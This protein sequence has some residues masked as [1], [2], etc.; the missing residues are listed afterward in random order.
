MND[1]LMDLWIVPSEALAERR[2]RQLAQ[3][4]PNKILLGE[5]VQSLPHFLRQITQPTQPVLQRAIQFQWIRSL[6]K[7]SE[8]RYFNTVKRHPFLAHLFAD[9]LTRLKKQGITP[10]PLEEMLSTTGSLKEYDLLKVFHA[11]EKEKARK[12]WLD[13]EDLYT[14]PI[15][16]NALQ[17]ITTLHFE[18]FWEIPPPLEKIIGE[19]KKLF[20]V[21]IHPIKS[22]YSPKIRIASFV[23]PTQEAQFI[24][25][26][27]LQPSQT[28][29]VAP[30]AGSLL[31]PL[32]STLERLQLSA[33]PAQPQSL[34][35]QP[36][37]RA[38]LSQL[39]DLKSVGVASDRITFE[40]WLTHTQ[41]LFNDSPFLSHTSEKIRN[42]W[43]TLLRELSFAQ[44]LLE[45]ETHSQREWHALLH[46]TLSQE[47]ISPGLKD[48]LSHAAWLEPSTAAVL[49]H[50][51][52][53]IPHCTDTLYPKSS[54][55]SPFFQDRRG[56][57]SQAQEML[58]PIFPTP[59]QQWEIEEKRFKILLASSPS[60]IVI[61]YPR[62]N[63]QGEESS[64]SLFLQ[65]LPP[66]EELGL[67]PQKFW[68]KLS[69][70]DCERLT[71][72]YQVEQ[73]RALDQLET[74]AY[75][76]QMPPSVV[77]TFL[78]DRVFSATQLETYASCPFR[79]FAQRFLEIPRK[80]EE[81]PEVDPEDRGT[82]FHAIID[83]LLKQHAE[84]F[85][86][87]E[88]LLEAADT[89]TDKLFAEYANDYSYANPKLY[90]RFK[91]ETRHWIHTTLQTEM[92]TRQK[93]QAPLTPT[94]MEWVFGDT[95]ETALPLN[96]TPPLYLKGR[97]D[98]IDV[99]PQTKRFLILDY[100]T[101]SHIPNQND[102]LEGI[103]LQLPLYILAVQ[104]MLFP[105]SQSLGALLIEIKKGKPTQG[106]VDKEF[107]KIH[108]NLHSRTKALMDR[109]DLEEML[110]KTSEHVAQ[111]IAQ[112]DRGDFS[113]RPRDC[114][115]YCDY[116]RICRYAHKPNS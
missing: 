114:V 13:S 8:L 93:I 18:N 31:A 112:M 53:F 23:S 107:N 87:L 59:K 111:Y 11:Y 104:K 85:T 94:H 25:E 77:A 36:I 83:Q 113:A 79:Y 50:P 55:P 116:K 76:T 28:T 15:R 1:P 89:L 61:T 17:N 73:E 75:H 32:A 39:S 3:G 16:K 72:G 5:P 102:M 98:R 60:E 27:I 74:G 4:T 95:P 115:S 47:W 100:K 20:P 26:Q 56:W 84:L 10:M 44:H 108:F 91:E 22:A 92:E 38:L 68:K 48:V 51:F 52:L 88:K 64:P 109:E 42:G 103:S 62:R 54:A 82:L 30:Q 33:S 63:A 21:K 81:S 101:G 9:T 78:K 41:Q 12:E 49:T 106:L 57:N 40:E 80:K 35:Q 97:I 34:L 58:E 90:E 43:E 86:N 67:R 45:Q 6:L 46:Q 96:S 105:K 69:A 66:A 19:L 110:K 70:K 24:A 37:S 14:L 29:I 99:D 2:L 7:K 65:E 71:T